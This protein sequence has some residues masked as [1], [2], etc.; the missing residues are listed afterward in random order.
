M[1]SVAATHAAHAGSAEVTGKIGYLSEWE[2]AATEPQC[3]APACPLMR[4]HR[5][6]TPAALHLRARAFR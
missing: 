1:L 3:T 4:T 5:R 6:R 2:L